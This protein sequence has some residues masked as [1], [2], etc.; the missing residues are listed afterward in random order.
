MRILFAGHDFK[1]LRP[2]I[3]HFA[4][5]PE[6]EVSE[7]SYRGHVI[8]D[9]ARSTTLLEAVDVVFCEWSLGNAEWYSHHR[10]DDQV[11]VVRLHAQELTLPFLERTDWERVDL[12]AFICPRNERLFLERFPEMAGRTALI[13]NMV[14]CRDLARPKTAGAAYTLGLMGTAPIIKAPHLAVDILEGLREDDARWRLSIKGRHPWEY[15]WLWRRPD[16]RS[17]Y[18]ALY[19][20]IDALG[21]AVVFDPHGDDVADWFAGIGY[22]LSTSVREGS[23]QAVAEGMASGCI[24]VVRDWAGSAELYP[25]RHVFGPTRE[26]VEMIQ[27]WARRPAAREAEGAASRTFAAERFDKNGI[28]AEWERC[29]EGLADRR[30][31]GG[32]TAP[33]RS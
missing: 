21:D 6:H 22:V 16:E 9:T 23:H 14:D 31:A 26:A 15:D 27:R 24:P 29:L 19:Q 8:R 25:A 12:L 3:R 5:G 1:F 13:Y 30:R 33:N 17:Y 18:E 20:R 10:R 7:D 4:E 11:L 2:L 28:V 32:Q